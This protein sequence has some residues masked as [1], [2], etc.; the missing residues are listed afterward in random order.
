LLFALTGASELR[1]LNVELPKVNNLR[2][3]LLGARPDGELVHLEIQSRNRKDLLFRMGEYR[4]AIARRYGRLPKQIVLYVGEKP[5]RMKSSIKDEDTTYRFH[6]VD[7]RDLDGEPL[8]A[9]KNLSDNVSAL[10][11]GLGDQPG[12]VRQIERRISRRTVAE[13]EEAQAELSIL[14]GL[15]KLSGEINR[16]ARNMPITENIMDNEI[17]A[18]F[19]RRKIA[20]VREEG[21]V[22]GQAEGLAAGLAEGQRTVLLSMVQ[23]RFGRVPPAVRKRLA[24]LSSEE[25]TATSLRLL[26]AQRIADLFIP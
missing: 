2:V 17:I 14:A 6:L 25:L 21:R 24:A 4:F 12:I 8:L 20:Q 7:I 26:D 13:R 23:K 3:D 15:R 19:I 18:P 5:L 1:W 11:T 16:E 10:L 22:A 9:S